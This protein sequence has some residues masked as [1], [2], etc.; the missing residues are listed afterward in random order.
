MTDHSAAPP[1]EMN[2][3]VPGKTCA[4]CHTTQDWGSSTWCPYCGFYP[5]LNLESVSD[6]SWKNAIPAEEESAP[7]GNLFAQ[8]PS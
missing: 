1:V 4:R 5:S 3:P 2:T 7:Q 6:E 8:L